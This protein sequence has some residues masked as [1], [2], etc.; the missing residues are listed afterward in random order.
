MALGVEARLTLLLP[1]CCGFTLGHT[2]FCLHFRRWYDPGFKRGHNGPRNQVLKQNEINNIKIDTT[3][4]ISIIPGT[5][6]NGVVII[7]T[8]LRHSK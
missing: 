2:S 5:A 7:K 3:K 1:S 4:T 6:I 8:A